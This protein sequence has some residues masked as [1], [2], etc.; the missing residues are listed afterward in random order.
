M[1]ASSSSS[2]CCSSPTSSP[3]SDW[4]RCHVCQHHF[5]VRGSV[6][7]SFR[8]VAGCAVA[9]GGLLLAA[10]FSCRLHALV[11]VVSLNIVLANAAQPSSIKPPPLP[12]WPA[13]APGCVAPLH[14]TARSRQQRMQGAHARMKAFRSCPFAFVRA[15][16]QASTATRLTTVAPQL[17]LRRPRRR[18]AAAAA[19]AAVAAARP[20]TAAVPGQ[21]CL[22]PGPQLHD[23]RP[24]ACC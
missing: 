10:R 20:V 23:C 16:M 2:S 7:V 4:L 14:G 15:C 13:A 11:N 9:G 18:A 3:L 21:G 5:T 17:L 6:V 22:A 8:V 19:A 24:V 1:C 12:C